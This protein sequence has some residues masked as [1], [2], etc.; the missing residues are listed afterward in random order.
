PSAFTKWVIWGAE[1]VPRQSLQLLLTLL[2]VFVTTPGPLSHWLIMLFIRTMFGAAG[3]VR[4]LGV[5]GERENPRPRMLSSSPVWP[6]VLRLLSASRR[7]A[8]LRVE[9][10][11]TGG[12]DPE[13][14]SM[15]WSFPSIKNESPLKVAFVCWSVA[16]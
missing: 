15:L 7:L 8:S 11:G 13:L 3:E 9:R 2:S 6:P 5:S 1:V 14:P 10:P 4:M 12:A 16:R